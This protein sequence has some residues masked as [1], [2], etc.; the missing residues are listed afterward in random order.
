MLFEIYTRYKGEGKRYHGTV[1]APSENTAM[2]KAY[3]LAVEVYAEHEHDVSVS[4]FSTFHD[5]LFSLVD[6]WVIP[7]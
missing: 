6:F 4:S 3:G 5:Q 2:I 7:V 1:D